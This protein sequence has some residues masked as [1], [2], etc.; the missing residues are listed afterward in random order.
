MNDICINKHQGNEQS[1]VANRK[2]RKEKDRN[3]IF[4][5][6]QKNGTGYLKQLAREMHKERNCISG[7]FSELKE[8]GMIEPALDSNGFEYTIEG[9]KV[10]RVTDNQL[11]ITFREHDFDKY[12]DA[13]KD[14]M[15]GL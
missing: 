12:E 7:R 5:F 2:V 15:M 6:I 1:K 10:Y 13:R 3:F 9:C 4:D 14:R 8:Q 11:R